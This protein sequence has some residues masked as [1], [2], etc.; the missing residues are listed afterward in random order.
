MRGKIVD[1]AM[2]NT[3]VYDKGY[4]AYW[5]GVDVSNNLYDEDT[6]ERR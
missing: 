3:E 4:N 1:V 2:P 5:E 6:E